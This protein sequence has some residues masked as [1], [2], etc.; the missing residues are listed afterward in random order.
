MKIVISPAK[1]LDFDNAYEFNQATECVFLN[2]SEKLVKKLKKLSSKKIS[3]LMSISPVLGQLNHDRYQT[4][5]LPFNTTNAKPSLGV[6]R[7]DVYR[8]MDVLTFSDKNKD[9]AQKH[10]RI[11]SGLYGVLKPADLIQPYRLE[12]GTSFSVTPKTKN[13]Y[14]FWGD[15]ITNKINEELAQGDGVLINLASNEYFKALNTKKLK[16]NLITC[17]FKD[18]KGGEYKTIMTFAK[19]ARGYMTRFIVQNELKNPEELKAFDL[20]GYVF[21]SKMSTDNEYTFTRG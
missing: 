13:L 17:H 2:E 14:Q 19:M 11:L 9:F 5:S 8:G 21:N 16:G 15:K 4:W 1:T 3:E 12:M 18:N 20:E 6:F 10:L 7:G